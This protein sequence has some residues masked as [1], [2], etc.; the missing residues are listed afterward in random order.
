MI[1][2]RIKKSFKP[3]KV[4]LYAKVSLREYFTSTREITTSN[5]PFGVKQALINVKNF[6]KTST[7]Y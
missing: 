5:K 6:F 2:K 1:V 4:T 3:C 7:D